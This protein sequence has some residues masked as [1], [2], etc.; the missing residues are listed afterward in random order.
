MTRYRK[1]NSGALSKKIGLDEDGT[2]VSDGSPCSMALHQIEAVLRK[3]ENVK[4]GAVLSRGQTQ[5]VLRFADDPVKLKAGRAEIELPTGSAYLATA[6]PEHL[7]AQLDRLFAFYKFTADGE[8]YPTDCPNDL[9]RYV[10]VNASLLP[11]MSIS[12][13]PVIRSD[14]SIIETPG[15]DPTTGIFY[16]PDASF[17]RVPADP[18][19]ADAKEALKRLREPFRA[20]PFVTEADLYAVVAELLTILI[21]HL[22]PITP[23]FVHNAVE[24]GSGKTKLFNTVSIIAIGTAAPTLNAEVLRDETE[25]RKLITTLTLG[26][27]PFAVFDNTARGEVLTLPGLANYLTAELY[28]DRLLGANEEVKAPTCTVLGIT[29]NAVEIAGDLTR[30]MIRV[31][32]DAACERPETRHFDFDCEAE[33]QRD[34]AE[35]VVAALT[36]LGRMRWRSGRGSRAGRC[37]AAYEAWDRLV[38]G[39]IVFAGGADIVALMERTRDSRSR[40]RRVGRGAAD[41][42]RHWCGHGKRHEGRRDHRSR[43]AKA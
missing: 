21:R 7:Q 25:L 6:K 40:A 13:T 28:G 5:V 34:R 22:L 18:T 10:L 16:A 39:A 41:A 2:P 19:K 9:A 15:Y 30:R 17:P 31:D 26:A 3:P 42:G 11:V 36:L 32:L 14:G 38:V 24:A 4:A 43:S 37:S 33:A 35:L 29:G 27:A 12:R 23:A 1:A 8:D 20:F